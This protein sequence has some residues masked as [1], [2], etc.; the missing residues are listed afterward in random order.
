M[1][2]VTYNFSKGGGVH[3]EEKYQNK[4]NVWAECILY[5]KKGVARH[6]RT[7]QGLGVSVHVVAVNLDVGYLAAAGSTLL[8]TNF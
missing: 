6:C 8:S 4:C 2:G 1:Q 5:C 7:I 3:T